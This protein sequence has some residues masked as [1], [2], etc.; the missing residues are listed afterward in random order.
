MKKF[1]LPISNTITSK[2]LDLRNPETVKMEDGRTIIP[3]GTI[4]VKKASNE[5]E[6][7]REN[8][9]LVIWF[10]IHIEQ[11]LDSIIADY[12]FGPVINGPV[13]GRD[14]FKNHILNTDALGF[15]K[16]R[17]IF[18]EIVKEHNFLDGKEKGKLDKLFA[19]VMKMRNA[20]AHGKIMAHSES[21]PT[22]T[23]F[24]GKHQS[25]SLTEQ[26]WNDLEKD[27]TELDKAIKTIKTNLFNK[28]FS[29]HSSEQNHL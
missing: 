20:F 21:E 15:A 27:F 24:S 18:M 12:L 4:D 1:K 11:N 2:V 10:A 8:A 6:Q 5:I 3:L 29:L 19:D 13:P 16:K 17:N 7:A 28:W 25:I 22:V 14:F 9:A 26:F 23:F